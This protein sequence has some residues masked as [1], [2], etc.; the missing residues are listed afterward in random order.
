MLMI[1][2]YSLRAGLA[3]RSECFVIG[4]TQYLHIFYLFIIYHIDVFIFNDGWY[5]SGA[6]TGCTWQ[7]YG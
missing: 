4:L 3:N 6:E 2:F 7:D 1:I 5:F